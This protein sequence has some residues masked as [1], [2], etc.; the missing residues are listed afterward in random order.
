MGLLGEAGFDVRSFVH[1]Y[2]TFL[3]SIFAFTSNLLPHID[4]RALHSFVLS[5]VALS[6]CGPANSS[7]ISRSPPPNRFSAP[8]NSND[9]SFSHI[10]PAFGQLDSI[11]WINTE[12]T[13][14]MLCYE[15]GDIVF[16]IVGRAHNP[17]SNPSFVLP[18]TYEQHKAYII[19]R[20]CPREVSISGIC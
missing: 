6:S 14:P 20:S 1:S 13:Q 17:K 19:S 4:I 3:V 8:G 5:F 16:P 10:V 2:F 9:L 15:N 11:F 18:S 12:R 7:F